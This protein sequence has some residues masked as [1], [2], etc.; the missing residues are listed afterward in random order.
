ME[1]LNLVS[2]VVI[3]HLFFFVTDLLT[4]LYPAGIYLL[5]INNRNTRTRCKKCSKLTIKTPEQN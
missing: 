5:K 4:N 2:M 1:D 3:S